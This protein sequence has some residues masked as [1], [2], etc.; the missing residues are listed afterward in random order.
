MQSVWLSTDIIVSSSSQTVNQ[1]K[2]PERETV[3]IFA[4]DRLMECV[5]E[6]SALKAMTVRS[7]Q[8]PWQGRCRGHEVRLEVR[9]LRLRTEELHE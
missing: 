5:V 7:E 2:F 6:G 3:K 9:S 4:N 8:F 1:S